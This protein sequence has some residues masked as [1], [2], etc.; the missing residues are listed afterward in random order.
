MGRNDSFEKTLMLAKIKGRR[1]GQQRMSWLDGITNSTDMSLSELRELVMNKEAWCAAVH[2][3]SKSWRRL[4]I[5]PE[6][7][8]SLEEYL[9]RSSPIF[10]SRL[11][12]FWYWSACA[13]CEFWRLIPCCSL[14]L[15]IYSSILRVVFLLW[16]FFFFC[17]KVF[18]VNYFPLK[19]FLFLCSLLLEVYQE[20]LVIYGKECSIHV[21]F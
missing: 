12:G 3:V 13:A 5:W 8:S 4:S 6:L 7:L 14:S 16:L 19:I 1:R 15:Q 2:G 11:F 21:L 18:K 20:S 10:W 17:A 9:Y